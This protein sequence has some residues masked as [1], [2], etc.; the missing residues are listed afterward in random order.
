MLLPLLQLA[1]RAPFLGGGL[2]GNLQAPP[3]V[4]VR[5]RRVRLPFAGLGAEVQRRQVQPGFP[6]EVTKRR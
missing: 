6:G 4:R 1:R 2:R 5:R 3:D